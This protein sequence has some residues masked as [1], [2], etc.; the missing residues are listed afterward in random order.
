MIAYSFY[1][2]GSPCSLL[3]FINQ[4]LSFVQRVLIEP[5][6]TLVAECH[7]IYGASPMVP[8]TFAG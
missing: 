6:L 2:D 1:A 4:V 7:L 3:M 5:S 8:L